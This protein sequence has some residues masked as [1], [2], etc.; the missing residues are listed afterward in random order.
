MP[1]L[2][3][4]KQFIVPNRRTLSACM[5]VVRGAAIT[6]CVVFVF[7]AAQE[8]AYPRTSIW[9]AHTI[10]I[11]FTAL[12][13]AAV[14][15][16][17]LK[18]ERREKTCQADMQYRLLFDSNPVPMWV[19][20]RKSLKF[21]AVNEAASR[22]YGFSIRDFLTMTVAD[23]RPE[24]DIPA[25]LTATTKSIHGLQEATTWRSRKQN[26]TV[27]DVEIVSHEL[28]FHGIEA[29]LIAARDV[30]ESKKAEETAQRLAS[31]VEFSEDAII[32]KN[33]DGVITNWNRAAERMYGYTAAE[34]VGRDLS[35]V[36]PSERQAEMPAIMERILSGQPIECLETQRLTKQG[37]R[38]DVSVSIS[39]VKDATGRVTGASAIVRDI[40]LRKRSEQQLDLQ[41]AALEAAANAIAITDF[42]GK[43]VWVNRA[44]TIMT[45]YDREEVL[46]KN[47]RLLKS[48][49]QT[50]SYYADLWST[51]SSGK[52]WQG[53]IVNRRKD[54][55][56]YTEEMTI[57]PV[58]RDVGNPAN[59][60]FVAIK[61]D[62]TKRKRSE[63]LLQNSENKYRVLFENSAD[64]NWLMDETGFLDCN[65]AALEMF[66]YSA[67]APMLHPADISPPTQPDGMSSRTAADQRIA[68]AFL[69]GME[70]FEW[71]HQ[72]KNATVF[73]AE[74]CLTAL[75][76]SGRPT[77]LATVRDITERKR[78]EEALL[79]KT[80]LLEAQAE[81]TIDGILAV[82]ESDHIVLANRQFGLHFGI[83]DEMLSTGDD[84]IVRQHVADRVEDP[85][86]YIARVKY[87]NDHRDEKSRDEIKFKNRKVFDRY[88]APLVDS[89][90]RYRGRIWYFRDITERKVAEERIQYLAYYD[91]LT[92]LPNRALLQDRLTK[93]LAGARRQKDKVALLFLDL[94]GFKNINDS[95][96]HPI[97]DLLL[98]EIAQRLKTWGRE[99][100]T[101][102]RLGGDE[103]L[104]LLTDIKDAPDAAVAAERLMDA[105]TTEFVV[106][107]HSFKVSC[108][109]GISIFPEHGANSETLISRADAAMYSAKES[110][111]DNFRFFTEDMNAQALERL[112][113]E[114]GLRVALNKEELFLVYQP[115]M[116]VATGRITG[117]EALLR[118]QHPDLGLVPPDKFIRIAEN[119]GLIV[120]IGEWVLRTAC[121]QAQ[122]WQAEGLP[123]VT[124]AVNVSAIQFRQEGF[125]GFIRKVLQET[126][127]APQYLELE[128][129]ESLLLANADLMLSV[130]QELKAMG[131]ALAIDDFG[132][133]YS[134]FAY[135]RQFRVSKLKIDRLFIRDVAIDPD[136]AAITAAII[137]MAKSLRLKV[138]AEGVENEAQMSFLRAHHCDE[139][140]GYYFSKPLAGENVADKLRGSSADR[141][142]REKPAGNI[143]DNKSYEMGIS[144]MSIGLALLVSA[145]PATIQQFSLA[146]R[147]LSISPD[148]CQDAASAGL[149]L[150]SRKFDAVIVDLQLGGQSGQILDEVHLSPSNRT[151]VTFGISDNDAEATAAFRKKS[152]FV[153]ERPFSPQSIHKT[154]KPAYGLIL[155]ERRRYFRYLVS[156]P[157]IL[158]REG[159]EEVR[160]N[161]VNISGGGMAVSTEVVFL[162]GENV[163]VQFTLPDHHAQF[164]AQSTICWSKAGSY[165]IRFLSVSDENKSQLQT[166]L[167][168]KLEATLPE[169]VAKQFRKAELCPPL[170]TLIT[171]IA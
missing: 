140:Q 84:Q 149:L 87:L 41:S 65:S 159:G 92:G 97:G 24:K 36:F 104:I 101:V 86:A 33:I 143:P 142:A 13:T 79:F 49:E 126:G 91:A 122:K 72:R 27:I 85:E 19:F 167:S 108:S 83:T 120:P 145:D 15:S 64:A 21:L 68:A 70:R 40:T 158:Q 124:I 137:S 26:G 55:T 7:E 51:I 115:Q 170:T 31:I 82:D 43:I 139:I 76:L 160:C 135:L 77:L 98:Q 93:T 22:Q 6:G 56:T 52:V 88:S 28:C 47:T 157:V 60:Y 138:I 168:E 125:C 150:K 107:G 164:L 141:Q 10:F 73:P 123:P 34:A 100:D 116:D 35:I 39:P 9:I 110:G 48:G 38:L 127:L 46:G 166:W 103:F 146:L 37:S 112:T 81:T 63:E 156:I 67:E 153:F 32:G 102:A 152:Q 106:Q 44:F 111:R 162:P 171:P 90:S 154:L 58:T 29:E 23:I 117:L 61:Q 18:K 45:G 114:N 8:S 148:A 165:G 121:A 80:A 95:L 109:I 78:V 118:W 20:D 132:T 144:F 89:R 50:E 163:Q 119:S 113:L 2:G 129:T 14:T 16:V 1:G 161:C 3:E 59:R 130:I 17:V 54:G 12:A 136:D 75:T 155:R 71:M 66:G 134:S 94:D 74:V 128:L 133:G 96:G 57:T 53:E 131:L 99:R 69:N 11:L 42:E 105:M 30:T 147:D 62:V 25:L 4:L 169:F 5:R 151:A